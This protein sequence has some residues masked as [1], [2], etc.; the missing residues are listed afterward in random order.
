MTEI[1]KD[2]DGH[3]GYKVSNLGNVLSVGRIITLSDGRTK[4]LK[5]CL[6]G[7]FLNK[8]GY[9]LV[10]L[11]NHKKYQVHR[12]VAESFIPNPENKPQVNHKNGIKSDNRVENLEWVTQSENQKHS[13]HVLGHTPFQIPVKIGK[14]HPSSKIILQIINGKIIAEYCCI[15]EAQRETG[16][17]ASA[18]CRVCKN[19][20][21]HAGKYQW[22]Y[23]E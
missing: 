10:Q 17:K 16:I 21:K 20:R 3:F 4:T 15:N 22:K 23:K 9:R 2:I 8:D 18:I 11:N 14:N 13:V 1:W 19:K 12:L 6:L 7:G 5:E